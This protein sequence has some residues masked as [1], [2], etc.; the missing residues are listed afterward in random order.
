MNIPRDLRVISF[1]TDLGWM[2]LALRGSVVHQLKFGFPSEPQLLH[3]FEFDIEVGK[4]NSQLRKWRVA[5][6]RFASGREQDLS[7]IDVD[8]TT[9]SP[10][11]CKVLKTC[12]KIGYG[13]TLT[14]GQ[15]ASQ[16]GS[17]N[18]ARAVGT[19]MKQNRYPLIVP[20]HRVVASNGI[21]GYS[22]A[23]GISLKKKLLAM[24]GVV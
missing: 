4:A 8:F 6:Q 13:K 7:G 20:C 9:Y 12:R 18:A 2:G 5:L 22:A 15:L 10:F 3:A 19:A 16:S 11:Q 17:P 21:G 23:S 14:Y 1:P 24:E